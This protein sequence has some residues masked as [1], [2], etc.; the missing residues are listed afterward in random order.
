M[1]IAH[2]GSGCGVVSSFDLHPDITLYKKII[3]FYNRRFVL[4][5]VMV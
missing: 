3:V 5:K 1:C 2:D 4:I